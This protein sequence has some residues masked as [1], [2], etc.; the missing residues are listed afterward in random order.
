MKEWLALAEI[1][2]LTGIS[3]TGL[4]LA[5]KR[6]TLK[7]S[8]PARKILVHQ[9]DLKAFFDRGTIGPKQTA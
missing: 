6:G 1:E 4:M 9:D 5:I 7:A 8:K 2:K 3:R